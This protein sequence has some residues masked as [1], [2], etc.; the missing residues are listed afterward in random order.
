M[1]LLA[2]ASIVA[3][4]VVAV[5]CLALVT[6]LVYEIKSSV[7]GVA[8]TLATLGTSG[9]AAE[10]MIDQ[11]QEIGLPLPVATPQEPPEPLP[12]QPAETVKSI[13]ICNR[14]PE[15]QAALIE[16]MG[17]PSCQSITK[18]ELYR[19]RELGVAAKSIE[20]GDFADMPNIRNLKVEALRLEPESFV[21]LDLE[22]LTL[23][24]ADGDFRVTQTHLKGLESL[25]RLRLDGDYQVGPNAFDD[26][27]AL[28]YLS[29]SR[30]SVQSLHSRSF[31][32]LPNL[33]E[34]TGAA[35]Q[36]DEIHFANLEVACYHQGSFVQSN[37]KRVFVEGQRIE[38]LEPNSDDRSVSCRFIV[39][40]Q[41][42]LVRLATQ[43]Q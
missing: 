18:E 10:N 1:R 9:E 26:L 21:G 32:S 5:V 19:V 42:R 35:H 27:A 37:E 30:S 7:D 11:A 24:L 12:D 25:S 38:W 43:N 8:N 23:S 2:Q 15:V 17:I 34:L 6:L 3:V 33:K 4:C 41:V 36:L 40:N 13:N 39:D 14:T 22:S 28:E 29:I 20:S 31:E 16:Q